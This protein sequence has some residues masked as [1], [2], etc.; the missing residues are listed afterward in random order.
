M[1]IF[2]SVS[3]VKPC[4]VR[5]QLRSRWTVHSHVSLCGN[6]TPCWSPLNKPRLEISRSNSASHT[7]ASHQSAHGGSGPERWSGRTL[8]NQILCWSDKE[9]TSELVARLN[10]SLFTSTL[11]LKGAAMR[12]DSG[13]IIKAN[14]P[15]S[16]L[17]IVVWCEC[18]NNM[19]RFVWVK[20]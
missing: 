4:V 13:V 17:H 18:D 6:I 20:V 8:T 2:S 19:S 10:G 3:T 5:V 12:R 16:R 7:P 9:P 11:G 14:G 1:H 15:Q